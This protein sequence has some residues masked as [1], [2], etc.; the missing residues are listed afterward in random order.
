FLHLRGEQARIVIEQQPILIAAEPRHQR[1]AGGGGSGA[2][3]DQSQGFARPARQRGGKAPRKAR[4]ACREIGAL[5]QSQPIPRE[6]GHRRRRA[7]PLR[8][9]VTASSQSGSARP[10]AAAPAARRAR[11]AG[12]SIKRDSASAKASASPGA[13]RMPAASG[14]VVGM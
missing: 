8:Q 5:A 7:T 6:A 14:T 4:I 13:T 11:S 1:P 3:I 12:S 9:R 10:A 2:E